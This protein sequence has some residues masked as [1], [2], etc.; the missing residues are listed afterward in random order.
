LES[1]PSL[2][3]GIKKYEIAMWPGFIRVQWWTLVNTVLE[4][5]VSKQAG[6]LNAL[7][8]LSFLRPIKHNDV[9]LVKLF[10]HQKN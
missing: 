3:E 6:E 2:T 4:L 1:N 8:T 7:T 9:C 5:L 10:F